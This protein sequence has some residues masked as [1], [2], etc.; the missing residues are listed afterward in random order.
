MHDATALNIGATLPRALGVVAPACIVAASY[1]RFGDGPGPMQLLGVV[2]SRI[3]GLA[4]LTEL[5]PERPGGM[6]FN[7]GDL[8]I[9]LNLVVCAE[10]ACLAC[11]G[12]VHTKLPV[13]LCRHL[14]RSH[15]LPFATWEDSAWGGE[16]IAGAQQIGIGSPQHA[17]P[18]LATPGIGFGDAK[19]DQQLEAMADGRSDQAHPARRGR[20]DFQGL[21]RRCATVRTICKSP[22]MRSAGHIMGFAVRRMSAPSLVMSRRMR[23]E[24]ASRHV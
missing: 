14:G 15:P 8:I 2:I 3:G 7:G 4:I 24:A 17:L 13:R 6:T 21:E 18:L 16:R 23:V 22:P 19:K 12:T 1:L 11:A 20:V 10:G 5:C 9:I